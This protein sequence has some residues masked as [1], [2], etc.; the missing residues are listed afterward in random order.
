MTSKVDIEPKT[1]HLET[2][3]MAEKNADAP[4][5]YSGAILTRTPAETKLVKKLD[6]RIMACLHNV[7]PTTRQLI[8]LANPVAHVLVELPRS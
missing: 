2:V 8:S 4:R 6:Y 1:H 3:D 5:D 7:I